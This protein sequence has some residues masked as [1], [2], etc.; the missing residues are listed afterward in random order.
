MKFKTLA[1]RDFVAN[2]A[3]GILAVVV[4]ALGFGFWSFLAQAYAV[5]IV[6]AVWLWRK[7]LWTPSLSYNFV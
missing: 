7:P 6:N 5:C 4:A 3:G 2:L 1:F